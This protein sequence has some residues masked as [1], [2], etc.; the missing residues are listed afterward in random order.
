MEKTIEPHFVPHGEVIAVCSRTIRRCVFL[1]LGLAA[2]VGECQCGR[3]AH[4][5]PVNPRAG[6]EAIA[7]FDRNGDGVLGGAELDRC[8]GLKAALPQ[9]DPGKT[10]AVQR[11]MIDARIAQWRAMGQNRVRCLV[12]RNG[13]PLPGARWRWCPR[14]SLARTSKR[15]AQ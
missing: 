3:R 9:L 7:M 11:Q 10:G 1:A 2:L 13:R 8:P 4:G 14:S 6:A 12:F 15:R 5:P